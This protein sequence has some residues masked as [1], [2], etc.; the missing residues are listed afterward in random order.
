MLLVSWKKDVWLAISELA[1]H[2][3]SHLRL[4]AAES[5]KVVDG[6][7]VDYGA[8]DSEGGNEQNP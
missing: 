7:L 8:D 5:K 2:V 1:I 3:M 4:L 6:V